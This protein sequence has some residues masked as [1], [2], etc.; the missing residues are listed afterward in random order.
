MG[1]KTVYTENIL[2]QETG[3]IIPKRWITKKAETT[4]MFVRTYVDD[5]CKLA[6]CNKSEQSF[7]LCSLKYL[8]YNTN[9]LVLTPGRRTEISQCADIKM[10]TLNIAVSSLYKKNILIKVEQKTYLNP[11]LFFFGTD[12]ERNKCFNLVINYQ[13]GG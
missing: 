11:K 8:D 7:I 9:E 6:K 2:D 10:N 13:I 1:T 4:E 5:I 3:E 12:I